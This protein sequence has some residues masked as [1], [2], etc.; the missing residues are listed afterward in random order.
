MSNV[1]QHATFKQEDIKNFHSF[2]DSLKDPNLQ[3]LIKLIPDNSEDITE[4]IQ[5]N[6]YEFLRSSV[7]RQHT[8]ILCR[9]MIDEINK[10]YIMNILNPEEKFKINQ[11][12]F[13]KILENYDNYDFL[14]DPSF[15][16]MDEGEIVFE[17]ENLLKKA[18]D[19][20]DKGLF[21]EAFEKF[22]RSYLIK[23]KYLLFNSKKPK[24][25]YNIELANI[26]TCNGV[27][28]FKLG[29]Y[30][31][32]LKIHQEALSTYEKDDH[33]ENIIKA[34]LNENIA[35]IYDR[36][37]DFEKT[38]SY[39]NKCL[40]L[41]ISKYGK[42]HV[43]T[44][45]VYS[46]MASIQE[47]NGNFTDSLTNFK[48][49]IEILKNANEENSEEFSL[50]AHLLAILHDKLNDYEK[51]ILW[52][53]KSISIVDNLMVIK[54]A[55]IKSLNAVNYNNLG[56]VYLK[57]KETKL[58]EESLQKAIYIREKMF[59]LNHYDTAN[60]YGNLAG[61]YYT[62]GSYE[63]A[64]EI[65]KI[66]LR[67][68]RNLNEDDTLET[69]NI[70]NN[71]GLVYTKLKKYNKSLEYFTNA[72][73]IRSRIHGEQ[74]LETTNSLLNIAGIYFKLNK[75]ND[76]VTIYL[77]ILDIN[78]KIY[79]E[80]HQD[81]ISLYINLGHTYLSLKDYASSE[82]Y[83]NLALELSV[84]HF[85]EEN[86]L[87]S[88][89]VFFLGNLYKENREINK[90]KSSYKKCFGIRKNV[91]SIENKKTKIAEDALNEIR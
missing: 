73:D 61:A 3:Q 71:L 78:K 20:Y 21:V 70:Y 68:N 77:K 18:K 40:E 49:A 65:Y 13:E 89:I 9:T 17:A 25:L 15:S 6:I 82:K 80:K 88:D 41:T 86:E 50:I 34:H 35:L 16:G 24:H 60:S 38:I 67:I 51:A 26:N 36:Y 32:A 11:S 56:L 59:G 79:G 72:Y 45:V 47:V 23:K 19:D 12:E 87:T 46:S 81:L 75:L 7:T 43:N 74:N 28:L 54:D 1:L 62:S 29:Y 58:C 55:Q 37:N 64:K 2:I 27:I 8:N 85:T 44:G 31:D 91:L 63:K 5:V 53:K 57:I 30:K 42:H 84:F 14:Q 4:E 69:A 83:Y 10:R 90:A 76:C 52:Y 33:E 39:Y 48:I 66:S 22:R